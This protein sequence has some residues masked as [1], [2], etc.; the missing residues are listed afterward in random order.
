MEAVWVLVIPD[1][2]LF[3]YEWEEVQSREEWGEALSELREFYYA[4]VCMHQGGHRFLRVCISDS[5]CS[6][7]GR[8]HYWEQGVAC[9]EVT[10]LFWA[11][12]M[13]VMHPCPPPSPSLPPRPWLPLFLQPSLSRLT[14]RSLPLSWWVSQLTIWPTKDPKRLSS[15]TVQAMTGW[16]NEREE[17]TEKRYVQYSSPSLIICHSC[18]CCVIVVF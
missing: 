3:I 5:A 7:T 17:E 12:T 14:L 2:Q 11:L 6:T 18:L 16:E 13:D 1:F 9:S 8:V 10:L 15:T 4:V